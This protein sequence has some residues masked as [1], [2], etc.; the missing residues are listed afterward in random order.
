MNS[1]NRLSVPDL[2]GEWT[3]WELLDIFALHWYISAPSKKISE[4]NFLFEPRKLGEGDQGTR[5]GQVSKYRY[6][7]NN[8]IVASEVVIFGQSVIRRWGFIEDEYG[9]SQRL[10]IRIGHHWVDISHSGRDFKMRPE[11]I[12]GSNVIA[13][14]WFE[15]RRRDGSREQFFSIDAPNKTDIV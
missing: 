12:P 3:H 10:A 7:D 9:S 14:I 1:D 13:R 8:D 6:F 15:L 2:D 11:F 4:I 5:I